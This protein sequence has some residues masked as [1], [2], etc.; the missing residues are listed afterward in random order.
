[1]DKIQKRIIWAVIASESIHIFCCVLPTVFSII[2]LLAGAGL[3]VVMP[4]GLEVA[5]DLIHS[6][7]IPMIVFSAIIMMAGWGIYAYSR[8]L[9]CR[10]EGSCCHQP[11]K[12]KKDRTKTIMVVATVLFCVN[13]LVY[14]AF[15][16]THDIYGQEVTGEQHIEQTEHHH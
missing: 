3:L 5:H 6:Y 9:N 14:F 12:S 11:C 8:K 7:E 16:R 2:G 1:M 10:T 13:V 4:H 15:H